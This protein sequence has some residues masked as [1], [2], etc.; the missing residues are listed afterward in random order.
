MPFKVVHVPYSTRNPYQKLL[1]DNLEKLGLKIIGAQSHHLFHISFL[2]TT[3]LTILI[4]YWKPDII[5]LHWHHSF[6]IETRSRFK[7]VVKSIISLLQIL[8]LKLLR[9]KL[10]W[11]VHNLKMHENTHRDLEKS[12]TRI[13]AQLSDVII[14]HCQTAKAKYQKNLISEKTQKIVII[15]HGNYI[16]YYPNSISKEKARNKL[17][18]SRIKNDLSVFRRSSLL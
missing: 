2:N 17:N 8:F 4:K 1:G 15:P 12:F 10:V 6:L 3:F 18:L 5:H 13:L 14:A 16:D 11:T 9:V 7:T